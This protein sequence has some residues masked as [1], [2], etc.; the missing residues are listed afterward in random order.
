MPL[1]KAIAAVAQRKSVKK[2]SDGTIEFNPKKNKVLPEPPNKTPTDRRVTFVKPIEE[3]R[4]VAKVLLD[5][6]DARPGDV[7]AKCFDLALAKAKKQGG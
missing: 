7:G 1:A 6:E 5:D 2:L 3:I 4:V